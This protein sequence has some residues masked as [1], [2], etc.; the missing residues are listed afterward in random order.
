MGRPLNKKYFGNRNIGS[1]STTGDNGI[2]GEGLGAWTLPGQKGVVAI[3][4]TYKYFPTLTIPDPSEPGG[5]KATVSVVWEINAITLSS[6]GSGDYT[7]NLSGVAIDS[8]AGSIWTA[9]TYPAITISTDNS[10]YVTAATLDTNNRGEWT[11]IDGTSI[12]TWGIVKGAASSAQLTITFRLKSITTVEK[13]SGYIAAPSFTTGSWAR[14]SSQSAGGQTQ[15]G[16]PSVALTLDTTSGNGQMQA[17]T[18]GISGDNIDTYQENAILIYANTTGSSTSLGDIN[19]QKGS[20]RYKVTT[21]DGT[22][23]CNLVASSSPT[24][25][26][27]YINA[28]DSA[29]GTYWVIKLTNHHATI[30]P[31]TGTQFDP[32]SVDIH[33]VTEYEYQTVPWNFTGAVANVSVKIDNA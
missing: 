24:I 14:A 18:S 25:G 2:G 5:V 9:Q 15:T 30:V 6:G 27:A 7:H 28:T 33:G 4:N 29:T 19:S 26:N 3:S 8:L 22:A 31:N 23:V 12:T 32:V 10:G 17:T 21:S 1:L 16:A 20:R 11:S 13:G